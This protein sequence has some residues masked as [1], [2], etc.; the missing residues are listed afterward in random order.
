[1]NSPGLYNLFK[2]LLLPVCLL[3][4]MIFIPTRVTAQEKPPRPMSVTAVQSLNF[5][6]FSPGT[7]GTVTIDSWRVRTYFGV[8]PVGSDTYCPAIF[9][10]D[11]EPG[12]IARWIGC[13]ATLTNLS[14]PGS[15][16][17]ISIP[18]SANSFVASVSAHGTLQVSIGGTLSVP[19]TTLPGSYSGQFFITFYQE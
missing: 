5:G 19:S 8:I 7:G 17:A 16:M 1:M 14:S 15:T 9:E 6:S 11:A 18:S 2:S 13:D 10:I 3:A 12:T 4:G